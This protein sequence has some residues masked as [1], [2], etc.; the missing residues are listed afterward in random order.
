MF[1]QKYE[2][3]FERGCIKQEQV[4]GVMDLKHLCRFVCVKIINGTALH[5]PFNTP[6]GPT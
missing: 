3:L 1:I 2:V 5:I 6:W 4:F